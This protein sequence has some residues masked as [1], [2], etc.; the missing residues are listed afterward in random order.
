MGRTGEA[1]ERLV[2]VMAKLRAPDGCPWDRVQTQ[3]SLRQWLL[4]ETYEVLEAMV[5]D[6]AAHHREELGDLLLQVVFQAQL[7]AEEGSFDVAAVADGI[8]E[9]MVRRHPHVFGDQAVAAGAEGALEVRA[10]WNALKKREK[11]RDSALDGIP[12]ALPALLR[13]LRLG[14]KA[15]AV[16]FDWGSA[17]E[18]LVKLDE[19]RAELAEAL[20]PEGRWAAAPTVPGH[21]AVAPAPA[22]VAHELGDCLFTLVNLARHLGVDPEA[23]LQDANARFDQR[24]RGL[25]AGLKAEGRR[26]EGTEAAELEAR[27]QAVKRALA[28]PEGDAEPQIP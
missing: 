8:T 3:D 7:R 28:A 2:A 21:A 4:E 14:Q 12:P 23:A 11:R 25:E 15:A 10:L 17:A 24:F 18:V 22:A 13:A 27:W 16:G 20:G 1:F 9:K 19:E 6:D 26:V 5:S